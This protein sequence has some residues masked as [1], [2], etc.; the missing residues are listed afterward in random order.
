M[1]QAKD[2]DNIIWENLSIRG[3]KKTGRII[4]AFISCVVILIAFFIGSVHFSTK[5]SKLETRYPDLDCSIAFD[6]YGETKIRNFIGESYQRS[7]YIKGHN[8]DVKNKTNDIVGAPYI[9]VTP[10]FC[11]LQLKNFTYDQL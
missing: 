1:D 6:D 9:G 7:L 2:P 3:G 8:K 11:K 4:M 10:C 5:V